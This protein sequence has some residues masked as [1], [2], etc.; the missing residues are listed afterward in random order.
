MRAGLDLGVTAR[1]GACWIK[2][3]VPS[4]AGRKFLQLLRDHDATQ[5]ATYLTTQDAASR[6]GRFQAAT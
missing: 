3:R 5:A 1:F 4:A 6:D 2:Q